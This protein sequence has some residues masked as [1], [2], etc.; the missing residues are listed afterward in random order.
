MSSCAATPSLA[1]PQVEYR[2][3]LSAVGRLPLR[4]DR[5]ERVNS[6]R[7]V[8]VGRLVD[9]ALRPLLPPGFLY[10]TQVRLR[11]FCLFV[12]GGRGEWWCLCVSVEACVAACTCCQNIEAAAGV[13][14]ALK[15]GMYCHSAAYAVPWRGVLCRAVSSGV[16]AAAVC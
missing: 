16:P 2:E 8:L 15:H 6:E 3:R 13:D 1:P 5:R 9:R 7:E 11:C 4:P 10:D 14:E 12:C